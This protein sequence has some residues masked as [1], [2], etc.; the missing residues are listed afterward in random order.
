MEVGVRVTVAGKKGVVRFFGETRFAQGEWVGV[1]LD[2]PDGKNDGTVNEVEYF[3][4][5]DKHGI[6]VRK[7]QV[8]VDR[9]AAAA[10]PTAKPAAAKPAAAKPAAAKPA[11]AKPTAAKTAAAKRVAAKPSA[12]PAPPSRAPSKPKVKPAKRKAPNEA[13]P[14]DPPP[15]K[16]R[17]TLLRE[18]SFSA[19][20]AQSSQHDG[21]QRLWE[22]SPRPA[23]GLSSASGLLG[24]TAGSVSGSGSDKKKLNRWLVANQF[25]PNDLSKAAEHG[26]RPMHLACFKGTLDIAAALVHNGAHMDLNSQT[27]NGMASPRP[28]SRSRACVCVCA[29]DVPVSLGPICALLV[30]LP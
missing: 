20:C 13:N 11:A 27:A 4:C 9:T 12:N 16:R 5:T 2:A 22:P 18:S 3:K 6:F 8:R 29:D 14:P 21:K 26:I 10:A 28:R 7:V 19:Q 1:E 24:P 15:Y 23:S 30:A 17:D 25:D